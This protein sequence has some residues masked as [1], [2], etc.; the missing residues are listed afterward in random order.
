V[1]AVD[2]ITGDEWAVSKIFNPQSVAIVGASSKQGTLAWWPQ[3]LLQQYGY[4]G[5]IIPINPN[6]QQIA[7]LACFPDIRSVDSKIDVAVIAMDAFKSI[8]AVV[9][10]ADVGVGAVVLPAQGFGEGGESGR[11]VEREMLEVARQS[12]MRIHGPNTDGVAN[13]RNGAVLSIQP[14]LGQEVRPGRVAVITQSGATA[15]SMVARLRREGIGVSYYASVGNEIDLGLA[16]YLSVALQ[17]P[18]VDIVVSFIEAIREPAKFMAV[19]E[20]AKRLGKPIVVIKVGRTE[21]AAARAAAHTGALAGEDRIYD[22]LFSS[23]GIIR[24]A[25]LSEVVAVTKLFLSVGAL[26]SRRIGIMSVSGGQAG[27]LA[28]R[29]SDFGLEV[30]DLAPSTQAALT[31]LLP[32][33]NALNPCDLTGDVATRPN[34]AADVYALFDGDESVDLLVYGRKEL[35]GDMGSLSA[36]AVAD[37]SVRLATPIAVYSMDGALDSEE[38]ATYATNAV[39]VFESAGELFAAVRALGGFGS[40]TERR[41]DGGQDVLLTAD[42]VPSDNQRDQTDAKELLAGFGVRFSQERVVRD[43]DSAASAATEL[44]YPVAMKMLSERIAHKS[45]LGGVILDVR[46]ETSARNAFEELWRR[47]RLALDGDDLDG[48]LVQEQVSGGVEMI[49]GGVVDEQFGPFVLVGT[50]GTAAELLNDVVL[51]PA[52]VTVDLAIDLISGLRGQALLQG[53]R[54]AR[55]A[56]VLAL[57]ETVRAVSTFMC[58][59]ASWVAAVDLN[60]VL[61]LEQGQGAI[62]VDSLVVERDG[63]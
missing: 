13:F 19:A 35:T 46:D 33:G 18:D 3:R 49:V 6:R 63:A 61:V 44:G 9:D 29:A 51:A 27:A 26:P 25:E 55:P 50:G 48:V 4:A 23:L 31:E 22:A 17:D 21:Q 28:D 53:F 47:G 62:A 7:G 32:H 45:E 15:A 43:D 37:A 60:P 30:P 59:N 54:G 24:V 57:A 42:L 41:S 16:D 12:G 11:D 39:P 1:I 56:D 10:C 36:Q 5:R 8:Q 38:A 34:L 40:S 52:P 2:S 20:L 58:S 14:V